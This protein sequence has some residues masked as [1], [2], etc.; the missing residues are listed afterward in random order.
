MFNDCG[1]RHTQDE[2]DHIPRASLRTCLLPEGS[3]VASDPGPVSAG[4]TQIAVCLG[5]SPL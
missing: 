3:E 4:L 5:T 2:L 1:M